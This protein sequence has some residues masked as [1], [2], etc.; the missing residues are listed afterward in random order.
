MLCM[1][2]ILL[3]S[4]DCERSSRIRHLKTCALVAIL[5][6]TSLLTELEADPTIPRS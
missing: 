6:V 3:R 4:G 2:L 1:L 5:F